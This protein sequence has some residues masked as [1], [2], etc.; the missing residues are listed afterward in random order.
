[1]SSASTTSEP[2]AAKNPRGQ[3]AV[4]VTLMIGYA[5]FYLC[6]ANVDA[7][8]PLLHDAFDYDKA[9]LGTLSSIAI[10]VYAG[11]KVI[12]GALGD[13]VGGR[14]LM[15]VAMAGSIAASFA[16]GAGSGFVYLVAMA[17]LNRFFQSGGWVS[18]V[19]IVSQW[20]PPGKHGV[21]MGAMSTSYELGNVGALLLCGLIVKRGLGWRWLFIV[22]PALFAL[23]AIFI[24][25]T[26][27]GTPPTSPST[28]AREK[29]ADPRLPFREA[30]PLLAKNPAFWSAVG[31][32]V[33]LTFIRT[34]FLTWTPTYLTEIARAS[35][36]GAGSVSTSIAKSAIFPATGVI[37]ALVVGRIS[38]HYGPGK[39]A[40]VLVV[41][42]TFHVVAVLVLAHSGITST[43]SAM[44]AIG[45][46]GLFLL[47]PYSL[48]AG[49][50]A[51]DLAGSRAA[52]TAA[53]LIDSAG[54]FGAT[55]VGVVLGRVAEKW[56]WS[57]AFDVVAFAGFLAILL[58]VA[59]AWS[60][61]VP[62][63]S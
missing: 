37:A 59:S 1:M 16:F 42:L 5:A 31:L 10:A 11:G 47:G 7:A 46:C 8:L 13:R 4:L 22:N 14:R 36:G 9:K 63:T 12:M 44:F 52:S 3:G 40:P 34:G 17:A 23:A 62:R 41:S 53:G 38:D 39:R 60:S 55:L 21:V 29:S 32:S 35:G 30:F 2:V 51:L 57:A 56:G 27:R 58:G 24:F 25:F 33:L 18:L 48:M 50:I 43:T 28:I 49:A 45:A 26:L 15:L 54:Y 61:R 19:Q 20:F 6:R